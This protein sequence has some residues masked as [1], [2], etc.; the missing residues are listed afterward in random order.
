MILKSVKASGDLMSGLSVLNIMHIC[1]IEKNEEWLKT[2]DINGLVLCLH[3]SAILAL[4]F[5]LFEFLL[6]MSLRFV[7][8]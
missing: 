1:Y 8:V 2:S 3:W 4:C 5:H 6:T 7:S